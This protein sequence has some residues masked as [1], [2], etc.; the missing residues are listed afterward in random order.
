MHDDELTVTGTDLEL[1][2]LRQRHRGPA[3]ARNLGVR[4][5]RAPWVA[6]IGDDTVPEPG[7]G[8]AI[9]RRAA[10]DPGGAG[11]DGWVGRVRWHPRLR[12]TR[13]M[14][15]INDNGLQFG[16]GLIEDPDDLPFNL[17]YTSNV[18]LPKRLLEREPFD[19]RFPF[20]AYE[21]TE[22]GYR[23]SARGLRLRFLP[24]AVVAHDHPTTVTSFAARQR[25][26]GA[27]AVT[28]RSLHPELHWF[29]RLPA[30]GPPPCPPRAKVAAL[31][32]AA[33]LIEPFPIELPRLWT[34]ALDGHYARGA[35]AAWNTEPIAAVAPI[36]KSTPRS[37][38]ATREAE[39]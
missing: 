27:S 30:E 1:T 22:L 5:A 26:A 12:V 34:A 11:N 6:L 24:D 10:T 21:D 2:I 28:F 13:F 15:W 29:V 17:L 35:A 19:E 18:L 7:W 23:L 9:S 3:A 38:S 16:F 33:R 20:A 14:A 32:T 36:A 4:A 39:Q 31:T 8:A 25:R 37:T